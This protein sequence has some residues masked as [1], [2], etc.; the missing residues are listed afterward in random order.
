MERENL[1]GMVEQ[2]CPYAQRSHMRMR[3][4]GGEDGRITMAL[5]ESTENRNA[6]GLV[7]AGALC[8]LVETTAGAAL[9]KYVD[10]SEFIVLN[11]VLNIRFTA[12]GHG[13]LTCTARV[14]A[15]EFGAVM[16]EVIASGGADKTVDAKVKDAA[17]K[18]VADA[19][20][21][22]RVMPTPDEYK[23]YFA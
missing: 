16:E 13:E 22:F 18:L 1:V 8:G 9:L 6:F 20:A 19:H 17:G 21:T 14:T 11:T 4:A 12:P 3:E 15:E 5:E 10:P 2:R 7:H 23:Q